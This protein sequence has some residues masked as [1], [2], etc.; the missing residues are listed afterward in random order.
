M[1]KYSIFT[2]L[3][4]PEKHNSQLATNY[5]YLSLYLK[6]IYLFRHG[7]RTVD[8]ANNESYPNDP[9][10]DKDYYPDGFSQLT[11]T[12]KKRAYQLGQ[13]LRNRYDSFLGDVYYQPNVYAQSTMIARTK[14]S[15]QLVHAGLYSP[16]E[17]QIWNPLLLWQPLDLMY[18]KME[19]DNLFF[20]ML[21]PVFKRSYQNMLQN[22]LTVKTKV[23]KFDN[24]MKQLSIYTGKNITTLFDIF[25]LYGTLTAQ[26]AYGLCLPEWTH[27]I[28]P[29]G[30]LLD[31]FLLQLNLFSYGSLNRLNGGVL[32]RTII[33]DM[34]KIINGTLKDRRINLFSAHD[35]NVSAMLHAL[36]IFDFRPPEYTS[37]III[38]LH[39]KNYK[40]FVKVVYYLGNPSK[41]IEK[42]IPGCELLCPYD[43]FIQLTSASTA[44]NEE[45]KCPEKITGDLNF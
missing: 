37:S 42:S 10:K 31:A 35:L 9:Y 13:I 1:K 8:I 45:L 16:A 34:D 20:S 21:C 32:L 14:T 19:D 38:E 26:S 4:S 33:N 12:G 44:T 17:I 24:L 15:L 40:F 39:E 30:E 29:N 43:K 7:D 3:I 5:K 27:N 36:N 28:F 6:Q 22:D 11:I 41:I 23:A 25:L 18:T 2:L